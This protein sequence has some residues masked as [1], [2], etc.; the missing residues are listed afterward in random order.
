MS[1][2]A[3]S[4][5]LI[6]LIIGLIFTGLQP[7]SFGQQPSSNYT[8]VLS[9]YN[10]HNIYFYQITDLYY[11]VSTKGF[12]NP[13]SLAK[14]NGPTLLSVTSQIDAVTGLT[15]APTL[16]GWIKNIAKFWVQG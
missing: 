8:L 15:S 1:N 7:N 9:N 12:F 3:I 4:L 5:M 16:P 6:V 14:I 10:G 2:F 11:A 13:N